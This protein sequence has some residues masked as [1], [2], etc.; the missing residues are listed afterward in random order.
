MARELLAR[1]VDKLAFHGVAFQL[2]ATAEL[3]DDANSTRLLPLPQ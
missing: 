3:L 2:K 1:I